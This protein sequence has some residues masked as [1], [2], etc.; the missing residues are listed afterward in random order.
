MHLFGSLYPFCNIVLYSIRHQTLTKVAQCFLIHFHDVSS[1]KKLI[2]HKAARQNVQTFSGSITLTTNISY[3]KGYLYMVPLRKKYEDCCIHER[4]CLTL[5]TF[6]IIII[7]VN[8]KKV[9]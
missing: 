2:K 3:G 6:V 9:I 5:H 7:M 4:V 8:F 1:P